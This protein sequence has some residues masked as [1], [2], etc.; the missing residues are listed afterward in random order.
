MGSIGAKLVQ[1][2]DEKGWNAG[3]ITSA[4]RELIK[5]FGYGQGYSERNLKYMMK[6][7]RT[8]KDNVKV[9]HTAALLTWQAISNT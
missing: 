8:Y 9:Q 5:E 6:F 2:L 3:V 4:S 1:Q 7:Y